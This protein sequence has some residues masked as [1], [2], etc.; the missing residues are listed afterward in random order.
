MR[1]VTELGAVVAM[2]LWTGVA[3]AGEWKGYL[4]LGA[5][6]ALDRYSEWDAKGAAINAYFGVEAP[7]G[8]SVGVY[9]EAAETWGQKFED[10]K[11]NSSSR[12]QL[13]YRQYGL[14][15]RF[16]GFRDRMISP[17]A[18]VRL[19][20][21]FSR[22]QTPDE[23]GQLV[24]QEFQA[25]GGAVRFGLDWWMGMNWGITGATSWQ[26]CDVR[27]EKDAVRECAKPINTILLGPT[28]RF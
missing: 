22:P 1:R 8:I 9:G 2:L 17:W 18:A 26:W 20:R 6:M 27:Y 19:A 16:R 23:L 28:V 21:S 14:E 3:Q 12:V 4:G 25:L 15:I 24:R 7:I 10:F 11:Q 13:D 5:G